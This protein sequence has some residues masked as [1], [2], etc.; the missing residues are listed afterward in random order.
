MRTRLLGDSGALGTDKFTG[1]N[2]RQSRCPHAGGDE[3]RGKAVL[4]Q[5]YPLSLHVRGRGS[6]Q[7]AGA[8][9]RHAPTFAPRRTRGCAGQAGRPTSGVNQPAP[10]HNQ[11]IHHEQSAKYRLVVPSQP[12]GQIDVEVIC[13][14]LG[15][16]G[17]PARQRTPA[18]VRGEHPAFAD[19][20]CRQDERPPE[21]SREGRN[22]QG[23]NG[24][25]QERPYYGVEELDC[26]QEAIGMRNPSIRESHHGY[27][28]RLKTA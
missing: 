12:V 13:P 3:P 24:A 9:R 2:G 26:G 20:E 19:N 16:A 1:K 4:G 11:F 28:C 27:P 22:G 18:P 7:M 6:R 21:V 15:E 23:E 14:V 8:R 17:R 10:K 25:S 5:W